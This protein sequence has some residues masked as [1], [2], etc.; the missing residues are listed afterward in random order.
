[1]ILMHFIVDG[2][3]LL[4]GVVECAPDALSSAAPLVCYCDSDKF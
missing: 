4:H 3:E 2:V 1:M